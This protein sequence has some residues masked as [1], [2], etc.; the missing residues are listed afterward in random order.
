MP[1][2]AATPRILKPQSSPKPKPALAHQF[3]LANKV[4]MLWPWQEEEVTSVGVY[5]NES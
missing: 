2:V 5:R 3:L 1:N 4:A